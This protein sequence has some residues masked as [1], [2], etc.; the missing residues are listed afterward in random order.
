MILLL[1]ITGFIFMGLMAYFLW[2]IP[3]WLWVK[4][5]I[6]FFVGFS[7]IAYAQGIQKEKSTAE[8]WKPYLDY[9]DSVEEKIDD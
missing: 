7:F 5:G 9:V 6:S 1:N 2:Q 3:G 8:E 4:A